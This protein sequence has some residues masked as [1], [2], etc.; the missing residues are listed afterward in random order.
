MDVDEFLVP[1]KEESIV[2]LLSYFDGAG[3]SA[4]PIFSYTHEES[5]EDGVESLQRR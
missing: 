2:P 5:M 4:P 3:P 1:V